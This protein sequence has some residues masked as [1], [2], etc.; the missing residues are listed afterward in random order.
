MNIEKSEK[1]FFFFYNFFRYLHSLVSDSRSFLRQHLLQHRSPIR[2]RVTANSCQGSRCG[3]YTHNGLRCKYHSTFYRLF[4]RGLARFAAFYTWNS[5]Y[6]GRY[7]GIV[8]ARDSGQRFTPDL[9]RRRGLWQGSGYLGCTLFNEVSYPFFIYIYITE[10]IISLNYFVNLFYRKAD[11]E[12][13]YSIPNLRRSL[14]IRSSGRASTRGETLRSSMIQRSSVR[15]RRS[16]T[17]PP[18]EE[19]RL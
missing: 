10:K 15:S 8:F 19:E 4:G 1:I 2:C 17:V 18:V 16:V 5:W 14:T 13:A 12:D 11:E 3:S 7:F 9:A 6:N